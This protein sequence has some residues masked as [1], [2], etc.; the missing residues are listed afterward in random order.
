[1]GYA[2]T[3]EKKNDISKAIS[4]EC[5]L[6]TLKMYI[7]EDAKEIVLSALHIMD[8]VME[9]G[10]MGMTIAKDVNLAATDVAVVYNFH[11]LFVIP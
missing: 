5:F 6:K 9:D 3:N 11:R 4:R 8:T 1:M 2:K 10:I 7:P